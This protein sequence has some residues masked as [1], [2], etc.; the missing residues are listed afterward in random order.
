[1]TD[2]TPEETA[3]LSD[4]AFLHLLAEQYPAQFKEFQRLQCAPEVAKYRRGIQTREQLDEYCLDLITR[5]ARIKAKQEAHDAWMR[6]EQS[7]LASIEFLNRYDAAQV[8]QQ[9]ID[10]QNEGKPKSRRK[11]SIILDYAEAGFTEAQPSVELSDAAKAIAYCYKHF[12]GKYVKIAESVDLVALKPVVKS[13][14]S[15][16]EELIPGFEKT[17]SKKRFDVTLKGTK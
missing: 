15:N 3:Q 16:G 14:L 2:A 12:K 5:R 11:N 1:M 10:E 8:A 6:R 4:P 9:L 13:M 7:E 17:P